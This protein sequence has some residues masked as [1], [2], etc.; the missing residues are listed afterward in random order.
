VASVAALHRFA[1][2][3]AH[4]GCHESGDECAVANEFLL[5]VNCESANICRGEASDA[6]TVAGAHSLARR[7]LAQRGGMAHNRAPAEG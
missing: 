1:S 7:S 3:S 5:P 4:A 6:N 2:L